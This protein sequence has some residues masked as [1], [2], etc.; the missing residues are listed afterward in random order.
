MRDKM[1]QPAQP[2]IVAVGSVKD[3]LRRIESRHCNSIVSLVSYADV[4]EAREAKS[5][6]SVVVGRRIET[7]HL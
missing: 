6:L 1:T 7:S 5:G 2:E 3:V 4:L